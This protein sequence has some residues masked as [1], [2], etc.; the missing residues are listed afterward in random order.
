M[1]KLVKEIVEDKVINKLTKL[2]SLL[3]DKICIEALNEV[4]IN[5]NK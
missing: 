1:E 4:E 3:N 5:N 2:A